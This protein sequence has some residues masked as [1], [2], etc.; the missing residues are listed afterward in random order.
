MIKA[1]RGKPPNYPRLG[2]LPKEAWH[3]AG[4]VV[5]AGI[6]DNIVKQQQESGAP[7]KKNAP[8]TTTRKRNKRR[9]LR[10]LMEKLYRFIRV[11]DTVR[12]SGGALETMQ[13][14]GRGGKTR[15]ARVDSANSWGILRY[16]PTGGVVVG[17]KSQQLKN[18]SRW[19]Q[20]KGYV[21]WLGISATTREALRAI[22]RIW[23]AK[24]IKKTELAK[25]GLKQKA[26]K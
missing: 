14:A 3:D 15:D 19:V 5:A 26:E 10:S 6:V 1:S 9:D 22:L 17:A 21:G 11:A 8:A 7:I 25:T 4:A 20:G 24:T 23:I 13:V 16:L 2:G 12:G 18:L